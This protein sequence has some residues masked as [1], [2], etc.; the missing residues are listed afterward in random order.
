ML[1]RQLFDRASSTYTYLL[2]DDTTREAVII[3][4]VREQLERD[5]QLVEELGL[6][7]L[8]VLE[9]HVHA[10]HVTSSGA[11]RK[12]TGAFAVGF[13][14]GAPCVDIGIDHREAVRIGVDY[15]RPLYAPQRHDRLPRQGR[16][17]LHV[18]D[19]RRRETLQSARG[20]KN[21]RGIHRDHARRAL[22]AALRARTRAP[23]QPRVR[24]RR[25]M[26]S[27]DRAA[28]PVGGRWT[29]STLRRARFATEPAVVPSSRS[30]PW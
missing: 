24:V 6:K 28:H 18:D 14:N 25:M 23:R 3:D 30:K 2:A 13:K 4:P 12:R 21:A 29:T 19:D 26:G 20:G 8:F 5:A 22:S 10:D 1:L 16:A 9:T 15:P 7:L 11:L 27:S 17:R